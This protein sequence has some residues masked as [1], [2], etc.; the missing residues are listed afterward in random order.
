L[1]QQ[2][3]NITFDN[4]VMLGPQKALCVIE[5][6]KKE[7]PNTKYYLNF[8]NPLELMVA[9]IL[10][11]QVRDE[12]VNASTPRLFKKYKTA[13]AYAEASL[14]QLEKE[15]SAITFYKNKAKH[16]KEACRIIAE[17]HGGKVPQTME[18]LTELP[19]IG[20]KTANAILIN[21][22]DKT[23]GIV[24]DTH[25]IRVSYRLGWTKNT[26]PKKIE[27]DLMA[28]LPKSEWKRIT[29]LMKDHGRAVCKAPVPYCSKCILNKLCPKQ[30]VTERL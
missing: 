11:A 1:L 10:S 27:K 3:K 23:V 22:F 21:A 16:I 9:A 29:W 14:T 2:N 17:Q 24:V 30:G 18:A 6:L 5:K 26:N 4:L 20:R 12:V 19:C 8:S 7:Y 28:L 13:E 15:I 25:V